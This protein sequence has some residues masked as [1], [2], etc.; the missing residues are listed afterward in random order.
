MAGLPVICLHA[1]RLPVVGLVLKR[2]VDVLGAGLALIVLSPFLAGDRGFYE[3]RFTGS[4]SLLRGT[5]RTQRA[6]LP[7]LQVSH[8]GEQC[9]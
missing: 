4:G 7:L 2:L 6:A 3:A 8:D 5:G 1:E 9:R